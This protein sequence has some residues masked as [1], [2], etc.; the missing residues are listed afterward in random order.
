MKRPR[1]RFAMVSV[2]LLFIVIFGG[3]YYIFNT[4]TDVFQPVDT[5]NQGKQVTLKITPGEST[6]DIADQLQQK[7]LIRNAVAFRIWARIKG[8]DTKI[9]AGVYKQLYSSMT[10]DKIV[11]TLLDGQPDAITVV[12]PEGKRLEE[13]A[14]KLNSYGLAKFNK[15][16]FLKYVKHIDQF[17]DRNKYPI[18]KSV[19]PGINSME[20]LLFPAGYDIDV[21]ANASQVIGVMLKQTEDVIQENHLDT[22]AK[23]HQMT[24]YQMITLASIVERETLFEADRGNIASVYWNRLYREN[25]E[26]AGFLNADPTVQYARD[27]Q[28][29]PQKYWGKIQGDPNVIAADSKYNTYKF[30]GLPPTPIC[31]PG[32]SS[33]QKSANPPQTNYYFF[34]AKPD[35]HS[36]FDE[37]LA[38]FT[39]D[40]QKYGVSGQ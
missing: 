38:K 26:T 23:Q 32:L 34:F 40:Q 37:N 24:L 13:I 19:P 2:L 31:S 36:I 10:I 29:T 3:V 14:S 5:S 39:A 15:D 27:S 9:Q 6:A 25:S 12:I 35:G 22:E 11:S 30:Q 17:P 7:G 33:L 8:L 16:D 18:L 28:D 21:E 4:A 20:G 1:S